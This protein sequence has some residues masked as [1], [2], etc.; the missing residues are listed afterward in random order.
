MPAALR[1]LPIWVYW[2][3][4]WKPDRAGGGRWSK[5]P[6]CVWTRNK[7]A[8]SNDSTTW[9]TYDDACEQWPHVRMDGLGIMIRHGLVGMDIDNCVDPD[10]REINSIAKGILEVLGAYCEY[11]PTGT[12]IKALFYGSRE[13]LL[14]LPELRDI[15]LKDLPIKIKIPLGF[16]V[17]TYDHSSPRYF[18]ITGNRVE[19]FPADIVDCR[20]AFRSLYVNIYKTELPKAKEHSQRRQRADVTL[21]EVTSLGVA[22]DKVIQLALA[23]RNGDKFRSLYVDGSLSG[24]LDDQSRA[25]LALCQNLA[26]WVGADEARIDRLFRSS[27]LMRPKW[28]RDDYRSRTI[29]LAITN[30][31]EYYEWTNHLDG[32]DEAKLDEVFAKKPT[33]PLMM[34]PTQR[35]SEKPT[36]LRRSPRTKPSTNSGTTTSSATCGVTT[37]VAWTTPTGNAEF[38]LSPRC[39]TSSPSPDSSSTTWPPNSPPPIAA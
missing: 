19:G 23:A 16:E 37:T 4:E 22:D 25:D 32:E 26:F 5:T 6:Y 17:E 8:R 15:Q 9:V 28:E 14:G 31:V 3:A 2:Q 7:K 24:H 1:E 11:S 38:V 12:G 13:D 34:S 10:T 18:T 30:Q 27:A 39:S 21:R 33:S 36:A 20:K 29:D 35:M